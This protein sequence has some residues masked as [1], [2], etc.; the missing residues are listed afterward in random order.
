MG[1]SR[2]FLAGT[3]G[4]AMLSTSVTPA[5]A[6][7]FGS[8]GFGTG[9][10]NSWGSVGSSWG[11]GRGWG[12]RHRGHDN[13]T[14]E[15]LA[16]VLIGAIL[17]GAVLSSKAK[18]QRERAPTVDY[19]EDR[20]SDDRSQTRRGDIA[21]EDQAVDACA[22]AAE[23][24]AGRAASVRDI[25]QVRKSS[26]GWDVEGVVESREGWRDRATERRN[27][28]CSVRYGAVD[29]VYLEDGRVALNQ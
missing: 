1:F 11:G 12:R 10:G 5:M 15:V 29:S 6:G 18:K 16:G 23:D 13:D 24:K 4:L 21:S 3:L 22:Q 9:W 17:T 19:P 28:T 7:G 26:D 14:G 25:N 27:F 20:R 2:K 8:V